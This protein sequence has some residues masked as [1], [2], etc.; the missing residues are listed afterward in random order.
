MNSYARLEDIHNMNIEHGSQEPG[1][2][3][4]L[5]QPSGKG[6]IINQ[7]SD[8]LN[9]RQYMHHRSLSHQT[10]IYPSKSQVTTT[11]HTDEPATY[12]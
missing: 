2:M 3:A 9:I 8:R 4:L 5:R 7:T 1:V 11:P 10:Y 12:P 6:I